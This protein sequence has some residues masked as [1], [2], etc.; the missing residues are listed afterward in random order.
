MVVF[1]LII[2]RKVKERWA[3]YGSFGLSRPVS[4][5]AA[6][7]FATPRRHSYEEQ[8]KSAFHSPGGDGIRSRVVCLQDEWG[9]SFFISLF[10]FFLFLVT[11]ATC[12][13]FGGCIN[14]VSESNMWFQRGRNQKEE[15]RNCTLIEQDAYNEIGECLPTEHAWLVEWR[16]CFSCDL[17]MTFNKA[18]ISKLHPN[19]DGRLS[20]ITTWYTTLKPML[21]VVVQINLPTSSQVHGII[22]KV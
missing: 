12:R 8:R 13:S 22:F 6:S 3:R 14:D 15:S 5:S 9:A 20:W 19:E 11:C 1:F 21:F 18:R 17:R 2:T 10:F 16:E 7:G 4:R